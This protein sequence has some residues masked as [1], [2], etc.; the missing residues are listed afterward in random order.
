[1]SLSNRIT[2]IRRRK[3][4][5]PL[6]L[7]E[8]WKYR[9]LLYFLTKRDIQVR[10]R[11]T[12]L[13]GVWAV[14]QP[15]LTMIVF[16]VLFGRLAKMPS[17]GAPYPVFVYSGLLAWTYFA[18]TITTA[19]NSLVGSAN[20]IKKVYFP[21]IVIPAGSALAGLVDFAIAFAILLAMMVYYRVY[22]GF[23]M[24]LIPLLLLLLFGFAV[25]VGLWL[26]ALNVAY[27]DIRH[28]I[29]FLIQI[30]LFLS[31]VIYPSSLVGSK[32]KF[33][34]ALNPVSGIIEAMRWCILSK[35]GMDWTSLAVSVVTTAVILVTGLF[36]FRSMEQRFADVV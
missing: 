8:L 14:L 3:G 30:W 28:A 31:P 15:F 12:I 19:G 34:L 22:P 7:K 20:L 33:L 27:R 1:M 35:P 13:G 6:Q 9:E 29:P 25:G 4:I 10:Y 36:Y 32:W 23:S 26:S 11:Q 17:D 21:R 24:L 18:N 5:A 16:S 2:I